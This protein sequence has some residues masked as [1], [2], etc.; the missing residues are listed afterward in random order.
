MY[1]QLKTVK[2]KITNAAEAK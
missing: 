1:L 2:G